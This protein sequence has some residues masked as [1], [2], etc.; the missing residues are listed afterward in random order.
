MIWATLRSVVIA[1]L[2]VSATIRPAVAAVQD[3]LDAAAAKGTIKLGDIKALDKF[4]KFG[5]SANPFKEM[6]LSGAKSSASTLIGGVDFLGA[7]WRLAVHLGTA[8]KFLTLVPSTAPKFSGLVK[9]PGVELLDVLAPTAQVVT[10]TTVDVNVPSAKL[11]PELKAV[12]D[13]LHQKSSYVVYVPKGISHVSSVDLGRFKPLGDALKFFGAKNSQVI[14]RTSL[15]G[16]FGDL[17]QV[18]KKADKAGGGGKSKKS[19]KPKKKG[20]PSLGM[21]ASLPTFRPKI[22]DAA[23]KL[24]ADVTFSFHADATNEGELTMGLEGETLFRI[25]T[26]DVNVVLAADVSVPKSGKPAVALTATT[27][28]GIPWKGAFGVPWLTIEDYAMTFGVENKA[29]IIGSGGKTTIG[30]KKTDIFSTFQIR[31]ADTKIPIPHTFRMTVDDGPNKIGQLAVHDLVRVYNEMIKLSGQKQALIDLKNIPDVA[32]TG[33]KKG[34]GSTIKMSLSDSKKVGFDISGGLR[35]LG[36]DIGAVERAYVDAKDGIQ[37][38]AKT[39]KLAIGAIKMPHAD[40]DILVRSKTDGIDTK[41]RAEYERLRRHATDKDG[42]LAQA[43]TTT[44]LN[45]RIMFTGAA[46]SFFGEK[47]ELKVILT[48]FQTTLW[49]NQDFGTAFKLKFLAT[50]GEKVK[51]FGDLAKIDPRIDITMKTDLANWL[52]TDAKPAI[53]KAFDALFP[54][55][56]KAQ[57]NLNIAKGNVQKLN[58]AINAMRKRVGKERAAPVK[59]IKAAEKEDAKLSG[60]IKAYAKRITATRRQMES[61]GQTTSICSQ[62]WFGCKKWAT[63]PDWGARAACTARNAG[64]SSYIATQETGKKSLEGSKYVASKTLAS[65]RK[66]ITNLPL[67][68]DPRVASLIAAKE[69]AKVTLDAAKS[70][71]KGFTNTGPLIDAGLSALAKPDFF[72]MQKGVL[73]G[74]LKEFAAG[75]PVILSLDYKLLGSTYSSRFAFDRDNL[76]YSYAQLQLPVLGGAVRSVINEARKLKVVPHVL[77]AELNKIYQRKKAAVDR[78]VAKALKANKA[79]QVAA[80]KKAGDVGAIIAAMTTAVQKKGA[81]TLQKVQQ[82]RNRVKAI[83][84]K[85]QMARLAKA[86]KAAA[87]VKSNLAYKKRTRQST[88]YSKD[89]LSWKAVDGN[90]ASRWSDGAM[91][92]TAKRRNNFWEVDLGGVHAVN[93]VR[94]HNRTECCTKEMDG[95]VL[96]VSDHPFLG[97][98][99]KARKGDQIFRYTVKKATKVNAF[100]IGHTARYGRIQSPRNIHLQIAEVVVVGPKKLYRKGVG[101]CWASGGQNIA[102]AKALKGTP[103]SRIDAALN[104]D[105]KTWYL[106]RKGHYVNVA[107]GRGVITKP[108]PIFKNWQGVPKDFAAK[109]TAAVPW[110]DGAYYLFAG[111]QYLRYHKDKKA[112][113]EKPLPV[114]GRWPG[115][116]L[117]PIDAAVKRDSKTILLFSGAKY[118]PF[119][120]P[121]NKALAKPADIKTLK[122]VA[123]TGADAVISPPKGKKGVFLRCDRLQAFP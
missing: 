66:G 89:G 118:Q 24:P 87:Q 51:G 49:T 56:K 20:N 109:I 95:M 31:P 3:D 43:D 34:E 35:V 119:S 122:G 79:A 99:L 6:T 28:R 9:F 90:I 7:R 84:E 36:K 50:T 46:P 69:T 12:F 88:N 91:I 10:F 53:K 63:V 40:V 45:Q 21:E 86:T 4:T 116:T 70:A 98:P 112:R 101:P 5:G 38:K 107:P 103:W 33:L 76:G 17:A 52:K 57:A 59:R 2:L 1:I 55:A 42:I 13:P 58:V 27:F 100:K 75:K 19:K 41:S 114:K 93:E 82:A 54:Q 15:T 92:H 106:F 44:A 117:G 39:A 37:I 29:I 60:G 16:A 11:P 121:K 72:S 102:F 65:L 23:V 14:M 113:G 104:W 32:L 77:I 96:M 48:P 47:S 64:R 105:A 71:V 123:F 8:G 108:T 80:K 120:I 25:G 97:N 85:V 73:R 111:S 22:G 68:L 67:D 81:A 110:K 30:E 94:I 61:C 74:R 18:G 78:E 62:W 83:K 115:I 26:Q